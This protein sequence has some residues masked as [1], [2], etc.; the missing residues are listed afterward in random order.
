[1]RGPT[2]NLGPIGSAVLTCIGY[3]QTSKAYINRLTWFL[4][5]NLFQPLKKGIL[6]IS[7]HT[8]RGRIAEVSDDVFE[9]TKQRYFKVNQSRA[10][11]RRRGRYWGSDLPNGLWWDNEALVFIIFCSL[12]I[13]FKIQDTLQAIQR[14]PRNLNLINIMWK[15]LS[16]FRVISV[17]FWQFLYV[18]SCSRIAQVTFVEKSQVKKI[19]FQNYNLW[20]KL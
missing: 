4:T 7:A 5:I 8:R 11:S 17:D 13:N 10:V 1:M 15:K 20:Y 16:F 19:R 3:K 9:F 2:P 12:Y 18:F 14:Y 6:W